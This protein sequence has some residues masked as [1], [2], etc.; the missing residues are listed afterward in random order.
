L[1]RLCVL[2]G[3]FNQQGRT[4]GMSTR[5]RWCDGVMSWDGG[6]GPVQEEFIK[7]QSYYA[8]FVKSL[9][10][11]H[12]TLKPSAHWIDGLLQVHIGLFDRVEILLAFQ[13][14]A[15]YRAIA[16]CALSRPDPAR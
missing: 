13:A 11:H 8:S 9:R 12:N 10:V 15:C 5:P 4:V 14:A 1:Y 16:G 6:A 2:S 7:A 3:P